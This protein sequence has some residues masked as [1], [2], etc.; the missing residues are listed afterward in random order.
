MKAEH[1]V[2]EDIPQEKIQE[3]QDEDFSILMMI[4]IEFVQSPPYATDTTHHQGDT[5][6]CTNFLHHKFINQIYIEF[7]FILIMI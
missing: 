1:C 4:T 7:N 6:N 5:E 3:T 2:G